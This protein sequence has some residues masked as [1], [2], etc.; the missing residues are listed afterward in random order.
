MVV[1][2]N[3]Q[4]G[5]EGTGVIPDSVVK[6]QLSLSKTR[7]I[8][9]E[10]IIKNSKDSDLIASVK[11][12]LEDSKA[13]DKMNIGWE[14]RYAGIIGK[15]NNNRYII[16]TKEGLIWRRADAGKPSEDYKI[17]EV[18]KDMLTIKGYNASYGE[19]STRLYVI[20]DDKGKITSLQQV[21]LLPNGVVYPVPT[22]LTK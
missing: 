4:V 11:W 20:R 8:I 10:D 21:I 12:Q 3:S 13:G 5:W 16:A 15:Y 9:F 2:P 7:Q 18:S 14:K 6:S 17:R 1:A 22:K 19:N